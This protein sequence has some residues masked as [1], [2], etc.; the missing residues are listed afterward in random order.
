MIVDWFSPLCDVTTGEAAGLPT[1]LQWVS[2]L[3]FDNVDFVLDWQK[4]VDSFHIGVD[5]DSELDC[6]I[7]ACRQLFHDKFENSHVEFNRKQTNGVPHESTKIAILAPIF[8]MMYRHV[9]GIIFWW[10]PGFEPQ[11]L[12]ILCIV[13][14]NWATLTMTCIL[15]LFFL[16]CIGFEPGPCIYYV[17]SLP[18][19]LS[20]REHVFD[21]Y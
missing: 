11:T 4:V 18:T 2:D 20:S 15:Y 3:Q 7:T 9:F 8:M 10:W 6:I 5:D 16:W 17:L 1:T 14:T 12:H 21:I 13:L 19:E